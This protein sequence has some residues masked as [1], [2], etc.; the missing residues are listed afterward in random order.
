[1]G[2]SNN[3]YILAKEKTKNINYG[4]ND[5]ILDVDNKYL[6][7]NIENFNIF[8]EYQ[9]KLSDIIIKTYNNACLLKKD[10]PKKYKLFYNVVLKNKNKI[11]LNQVISS[12]LNKIYLNLEDIIVNFK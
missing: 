6:K 1:M 9:K 5:N 10:D 4:M 2:H 7:D 3:L 11:M 8:Y 12:K